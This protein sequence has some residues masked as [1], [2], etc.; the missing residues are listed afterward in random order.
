M[1][2]YWCILLTA[3]VGCVFAQ[4]ATQFGTAGE[5]YSAMIPEDRVELGWRMFTAPMSTELC[6]SRDEMMTLDSS[7]RVI[8]LQ[9]G[10]VFSL[11]DLSV[12]A[13]DRHKN[14]LPRVPI[15]VGLPAILDGSLDY[16]AYDLT[17]VARH[18]GKVGIEVSGYC[19]PDSR[20]HLVLEV[21]HEIESLS[22][23]MFTIRLPDGWNQKTEDQFGNQ[24]VTRISPPG[25]NGLLQ[26]TSIEAD[27]H[28]TK[29]RLRA[30]TNVDLSVNLP[31]QQWGELTGYQYDYAEAGK[32]YRQWWLTHHDKV[33]LFVF[34]SSQEDELL[35]D[36][37]DTIVKSLTVS[38]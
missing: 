31:W 24:V 12:F 7:M 27:G 5:G 34:S 9:P 29:D 36:T 23:G 10:Q 22:L 35:R 2:R 33:L 26:V 3:F 20:L 32:F 25:E 37:I 13:L 11:K 19:V 30:L 4:N 15:V 6:S 17:L 1:K 21:E 28:L 38:G 8:R 16:D 18:P 14:F